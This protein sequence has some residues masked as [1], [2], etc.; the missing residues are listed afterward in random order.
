MGKRKLA[1]Y[2]LVILAVMLCMMTIYMQMQNNKLRVTNNRVEG[3]YATLKKDYEKLYAAYY[4]YDKK[5]LEILK[6]S[7]KVYWAKDSSA[8][9][10]GNC[11]SF[12]KKPRMEKE[13]YLWV[14]KVDKVYECRSGYSNYQL[15]GRVDTLRPHQFFSN[16]HPYD[17]ANS[18]LI[19]PISKSNSDLPDT[20][21][22]ITSISFASNHLY[23]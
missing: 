18:C 20:N 21:L 19:A 3:D 8:Y 23:Q 6:F 13:Y 12:Y 17:R 15:E 2:G 22:V 1:I 14:Y 10:I 16:I 7:D 9:V 5:I 11:F 4:S